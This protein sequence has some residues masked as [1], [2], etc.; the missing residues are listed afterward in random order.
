M[1]SGLSLLLLMLY[2]TWPQ[3]TVS[4]NV[5]INGRVDASLASTVE[6]APMGSRLE[7]NSLGGDASAGAVIARDIF[8]RKLDLIVNASCVSACA[9]FMIPAARTVT[10]GPRAIVGFH[11]NDF[12]FQALA[13]EHNI[14]GRVC[15]AER[16]PLLN[17]MYLAKGLNPSFS[18]ESVRR[19]RLVDYQ[20]VRIRTGCMSQETATEFLAWFPTSDQ[21]RS[22]WNL[23]FTGSVCADSAECISSDIKRLVGP[24]KRI[25]VGDTVVDT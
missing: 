8:D 16:L 25:V 7:V 12:A 9:E 18:E 3:Q 19:L 15:S 10:F 20:P 4:Q 11:L 13:L 1:I 14:P 24:G 6:Q 2:S 5:M 22:L 23:T 21:L 17:E